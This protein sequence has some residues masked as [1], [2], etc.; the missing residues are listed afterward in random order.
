MMQTIR[1]TVFLSRVRCVSAAKVTLCAIIFAM[2][3]FGLARSG[4]A[5]DQPFQAAAF[6]LQDLQGQPLT[7][8]ENADGLTVICFLGT[9]CPLAK[10]YAVRLQTLSESFS[11]Q[12]VRFIGINSNRQD[13]AEELA[14]FVDDQRIT[15]PVAKDYDNVVADQFN[16]V[17]TPEVIVV[18]G[19][20]K[21]RYRGR[22]DDQYLPGV[23]RSQ[24]DRADLQIAIEELLA[25][26]AVSV[27]VTQPEGCLLGRVTRPVAEATVTFCDQVTR[28]LQRNCVQCH[29]EG[30]IGPFALTD[31][32]EVVGWGDMM[33]EV[34]DNQRM[35]P[36]HADPS[37]GH[38]TNA[39]TMSDRDKQIIRDWVDQGMPYGEADR[40][41]DPIEFPT[42]W[43]LP[44]HPDRV[45]EMRGRPFAIPADGTVEYQYFVVDPKFEQDVWV[46]AAEVVPG[47]RG[48]VHHSIVF[49]RPPDG[50]EFTG[51]GWLAA[52]V[53]GQRLPA[54]RPNL[55]RR[56]P[57]G[58]RLVFQQHYTPNG[59]AQTDITKV[60][61]VFADEKN[62]TQERLTL[63][64]MDQGFEL[65]P[66][67]ADQTVTAD[68]R[69]MPRG[70]KLL[71]IAPHMHYRGNQ[72]KATMI[73]K[74]GAKDGTKDL[75]RVPN[76]DFNWQHNYELADPIDL[77][78][79]KA[80][81]TEFVF[82]NS[83]ANPFNPDPASY[84]TWGDQTWEEMAI[85]F[86]DV[87]RPRQRD[88]EANKDKASKSSDDT[89]PEDIRKKA[90]KMADDF[91]E[92]FDTDG[93]GLV[94]RADVPLT[95]QARAFRRSDIDRDR[96]L[97]RE[98]LVKQ[99]RSRVK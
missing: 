28:V 99:F 11:G 82:D 56:I 81:K 84:V 23:S 20:L 87:S 66:E 35:P 85:A 41:P 25:G 8:D 42:G 36:W 29:H 12:N 68:M 57:A 80:I 5:D 90:E 45:I 77:S 9:E 55:A 26:K 7:M 98:E 52:Y 19:D 89:V 15:F 24:P 43:Q 17:R 16:V 49:I 44:R 33:V 30:D 10:L 38:F 67:D 13:S 59:R 93:D 18:D 32:D 34:I 65:K 72:F 40:L 97:N 69:P 63:T 4:Y 96:A 60:G 51:I 78:S 88:S 48:V 86:F 76:Y 53:P 47:N 31:Y 74:D 27:P 92:R 64:A 14:D 71:A 3:L 62:V 75:L 46:T 1:S 50:T 95:T 22:V 37:V 39:R 73:S 61:L 6:E 79:V 83:K 21:V 70:A 54:T 94:Q 91:L 2:C 58:S